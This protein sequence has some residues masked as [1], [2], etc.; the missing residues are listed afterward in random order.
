MG[1]GTHPTMTSGTTGNK[2]WW[3]IVA[4]TAAVL[5]VGG[6]S[7]QFWRA[8]P[9]VA[10]EE[11]AGKASVNTQKKSP[12]EKKV[13]RVGKEAI[14]EDI[15][16]RE[17]V[18]RHGKEV[19]EDLI[20]RVVI[21][22]ACEAEGVTVTQAEVEQEIVKIAK[23]FNL[24]PVEWQK[25]LQAERGISPEQ[26][27]MSVIF[28]MLALRKLAA[29]PAQ[30]ELTEEELQVEFERNYGERA[31][32]RMIMIDN[33][34]RA[35]ECWNKCKRDPESFEKLAQEYSIDANSRSLGG[36]I[37]PIPH[38]SGNATI[39]KEA[40]KLQPGEISGLIEVAAGNYVIL[41]SEGVTEPVITKLDE[42]RD[43][44]VDELKERKVQENIAKVF[45]RIKEQT[46]VHNLLTGAVSGPDLQSVN[47]AA[48]GNPAAGQPGQPKSTGIK[49]TSAEQPATKAGVKS[50]TAGTAAPNRK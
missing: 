46:P 31:K 15:L 12:A 50:K 18:A 24:D 1:A 4:G 25:M 45:A 9:G 26:Y 49:Q 23:R 36:T 17:C 40:F 7:T 22:Q 35:N 37:P 48:R 27:R 16:A 10:A 3:M 13:A 5:A 44:L 38:H 11:P 39:E 41:K 8:Q 28:P 2:R 14:T 21:Q 32:V 47:P 6:L 19:L 33:L 43:Q 30:D 29:A 34:R 20:N 42:V